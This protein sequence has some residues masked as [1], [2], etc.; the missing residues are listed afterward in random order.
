MRTPPLAMVAAITALS[1]GVSAT[2]RW[3]MLDWPSAA[4]SG[5]GPTVL[6]ATGIGIP[7]C[8]PTPK[9]AAVSLSAAAPTR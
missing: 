4:L 3:P 1:S 6:S 8:G 9:A 5:I 7:L 2:S